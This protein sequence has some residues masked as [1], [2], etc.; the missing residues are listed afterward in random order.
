MTLEFRIALGNELVNL[1]GVGSSWLYSEILRVAEQLNGFNP[2]SY[3]SDIARMVATGILI[4]VPKNDDDPPRNMFRY[5]VENPKY[6]PRI[7]GIDF[8]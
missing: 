8:Y 6:F 4:K 1:R 7:V 2:R 5:V 3:Q